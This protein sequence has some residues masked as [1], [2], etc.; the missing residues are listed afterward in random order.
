VGSQGSIVSIVTH[1]GLGSDC[2]TMDT[3]SLWGVK[4]PECGVDHSPTCSV[5]LQMGYNFTC[6]S[7]LCLHQ[8][9]MK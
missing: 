8:Q 4:W 3:G 7:A 2:C 1:N 6:T 5:R 9:V